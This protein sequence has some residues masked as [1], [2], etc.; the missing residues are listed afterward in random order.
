MR[1]LIISGIRCLLG[2]VLLL[3]HA[4]AAM[5]QVFTDTSVLRPLPRISGW[6]D[7]E[8]YIVQRYD[9]EKRKDLSFLVNIHTGREAEYVS[10]APLQSG[11][12]EVIGGDVYFTTKEGKKRLTQ[13]KTEE[14]LPTLSPDKNWV[15]FLRDNDLF[16]VEVA[17]GRELRFTSDGADAILN[18]YASWVYYEEILG[19][20]SEYRAFWWSPDSRNIAFYRFDESMVPI[21]PLY[22]STGQHGFTEYTRYPKAGDPNPEVKV[23]IASV[24]T[25]QVTWAGFN[26]KD[27]QYFG[28]PFW[29]PDG[30]GL[31]VQWMPR[32]QNNLKL[33]DVNPAS[34][35]ITEIY[36]EAQPTWI[37][38]INR[39]LWIKEGFLMVRDFDGWEQ[40]YYHAPDGKLKAKITSGKNWRTEIVRVDDKRQTVYFSANAERSTRTDLY[41]VRLDGKQQR[42]LTFGDFSHPKTWLSPNGEYLITTYSNS[43]TPS[44]IALVDLK[45]GKVKDIAD[46]KGSN[47]DPAKMER[48]EIVWLK[49]GDGLELPGRIVWPANLEKGRKYPVAINV[50]GGPNYQ[51]VFDEWVNSSR[52]PDGDPVIQVGFAHRGSG[53]LGKNGL[54]FLHR[55]LGKWEMADYIDWVKWLRKNPYVDSSRI[56]ISG[57][58]YGGYLTAMAL[59]YGAGFFNYGIS[60]YPVIDWALYDS[61]YTERYM[62]QPK[63]NPEGYKFGSVLTHAG[64]Y[65]KFGPSMLLVQH[66][67]MDDNVH[68]QNTYQLADTLQKLNRP[69]ELMVYPGQRHGWMGA[70][71]GFTVRVRNDF[72]QR[73]LFNKD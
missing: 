13:T 39:F 54:N 12:A 49:T 2:G 45:K 60:N 10:N 28:K 69:F 44:R 71:S 36:N 22:N 46:T 11:K 15:A 23:G 4:A 14:K 6:A 50:Y 52:E 5:C 43:L 55:N 57:G 20:S 33:F 40:I 51:A 31:L 59:T 9:R 56:F 38:W 16:V 18:G 1:G 73:Y 66:G 61:H 58:S 68:I 21:F 70:K 7:N 63:D 8:N 27:D 64:N 42:R 29:R 17:T 65:Q 3:L 48:R 35:E 41:S 26:Q 30:S 32:E 67:T 34:G 24:A 25:G 62:D 37:N 72:R 53:D 19:R 47:Y